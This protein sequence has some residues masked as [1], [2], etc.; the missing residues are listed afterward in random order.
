MRVEAKDVRDVLDANFRFEVL[1]STF[2]HLIS[3]G[4]L[5]HVGVAGILE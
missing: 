2:Q 4:R 5:G 1:I 3:D